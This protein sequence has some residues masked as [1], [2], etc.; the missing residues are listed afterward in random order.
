MLGGVGYCCAWPPLTELEL[1]SSAWWVRVPAASEW[2]PPP[3]PPRS[4][5]PTSGR[6]GAFQGLLGFALPSAGIAVLYN[7]A[8]NW[9]LGLSGWASF[10]PYFASQ[11]GQSFIAYLAPRGVHACLPKIRL[12]QVAVFL[13]GK[14]GAFQTKAGSHSKT[15][16]ASW[17]YIALHFS[18]DRSFVWL[19]GAGLVLVVCLQLRCPL[20]PNSEKL[21]IPLMGNFWISIN[22]INTG[23]S[24][25]KNV[26]FA[27]KYGYNMKWR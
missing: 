27:C 22:L 14:S 2:Q 17:L 25:W 9:G 19:V 1:R 5:F 11:A 15:S 26:F 7:L 8:L 12:V 6:A 21:H 18:E 23:E 10:H 20:H 13:R 24:H 3:C 4:C 16:K